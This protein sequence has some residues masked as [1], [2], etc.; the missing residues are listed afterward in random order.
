V[1]Q[2]K[3]NLG[4]HDLAVTPLPGGGFH[5]RSP[6]ALQAYPRTMTDRL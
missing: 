1:S 4:P 5:V 6:H 3:V 2:R